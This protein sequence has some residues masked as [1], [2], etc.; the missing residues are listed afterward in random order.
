MKAIDNVIA[1]A[2]SQEG[3]LEK[4]SNAQLDSKTGNAGRNNYTKYAR[5]LDKLGVY[6][7]PKNGFAWCDV[8]VDWCYVQT[9]GLETGTK[10]LYQP[11]GGLG[12]GVKYSAGYYKS[13]GAYSKTP[14]KGDQIFFNSSSGAMAHTG[15]VVD[16]DA[17]YVYTIE[18]NTSSSAGVIANGGGVFRKKY[19]RSY[20]YID[21]YGTPNYSLIQTK[22][23]APMPEKF[24]TQTALDYLVK[25][26]IINSPDYWSKAADVVKYLGDLLVNVATALKAAEK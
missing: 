26:G 17:N 23:A 25:R 21:G 15:L 12:A 20:K 18:G 5:D 7:G 1:T 2:L 16:V 4:A 8:F 6:N 3:Y 10:M 24:T 13:A 14:H 22:E 19:L 9:Y 11:M